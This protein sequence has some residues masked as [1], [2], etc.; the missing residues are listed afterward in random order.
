MHE[1]WN[2]RG[3]KWKSINSFPFERFSCKKLRNWVKFD[4]SLKLQ[5]PEMK[6]VVFFFPNCSRCERRAHSQLKVLFRSKHQTFDY[7]TTFNFSNFQPWRFRPSQL[8]TIRSTR[9]S[10]SFPHIPNQ[11]SISKSKTS[12]SQRSDFRQWIPWLHFRLS[13]L[14]DTQTHLHIQ[15]Q[16]YDS[17]IKSK[18]QTFDYAFNN[19]ILSHSILTI[20]FPFDINWRVS[21]PILLSQSISTIRY[22]A[23]FSVQLSNPHPN[24]ESKASITNILVLILQLNMESKFEYSSKSTF[25]YDQQNRK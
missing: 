5:G 6:N 10:L 1:F 7:T 25:A 3:Q 11:K 4:N 18:I 12:D 13:N 24:Y 14:F 22:Q 17:K 15:F 16:A 19:S 23:P 8:S 2:S 21:I 9:Y 20:T